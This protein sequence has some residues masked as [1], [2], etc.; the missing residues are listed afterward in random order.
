MSLFIKTTLKKSLEKKMH[1]L[2][3]AYV[4]AEQ[5]PDRKEVINDW[6]VLDGEDWGE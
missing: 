5:D 2:R 1:S 6:K 3:Q 4:E